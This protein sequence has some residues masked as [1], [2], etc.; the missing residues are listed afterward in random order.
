MIVKHYKIEVDALIEE[1]G[2]TIPLADEIDR[3]K[4]ELREREEEIAILQDAL[5]FFVKRRKK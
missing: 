3:L 5:G 4:H 2:G 1:K